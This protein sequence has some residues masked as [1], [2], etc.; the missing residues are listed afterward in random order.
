MKFLALLA[1]VLASAVMVSAAPVE[2][3]ADQSQ[4]TPL[5]EEKPTSFPP[6]QRLPPGCRTPALCNNF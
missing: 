2:Q 6:G 3:L 5:I 4:G 1:V